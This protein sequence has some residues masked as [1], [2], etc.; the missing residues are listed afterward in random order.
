[1]IDSGEHMI[2]PSHS[3]Y[4]IEKN[5][6]ETA[7]KAK[8]VETAN[9]ARE[10][11]ASRVKAAAAVAAAVAQ[12]AAAVARR[13][14]LIERIPAL[15]GRVTVSENQARTL[16]SMLDAKIV[17]SSMLDAKI[18][19]FDMPLHWLKRNVWTVAGIIAINAAVSVILIRLLGLVKP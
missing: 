19:A 17:D 12:S 15:E 8:A 3:D 7:T 1:V 18:V 6:V 11:E 5:A 16:A 10:A 2:L 9:A 14:G 13:E 4:A